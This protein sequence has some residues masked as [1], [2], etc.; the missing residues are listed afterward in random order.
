MGTPLVGYGVFEKN[1][2]NISLSVNLRANASVIW[3]GK[4]IIAECYVMIRSLFTS[5]MHNIILRAS[6]AVWNV[7][8][9][10]CTRSS[11][12]LELRRTLRY[13]QRP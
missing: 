4:T 10:V 11:Q 9:R 3:P 12:Y 5:A 8:V 6:R 7:R 2:G 1:G 13:V